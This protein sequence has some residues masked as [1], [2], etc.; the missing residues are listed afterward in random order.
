MGAI[1]ELFIEMQDEMNAVAKQINFALKVRKRS[2]AE[3][4]TARLAG[5]DKVTHDDV[6]RLKCGGICAS[7]LTHTDFASV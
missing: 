3:Y 4:D 5:E 2:R 1:K 7:T 6:Y